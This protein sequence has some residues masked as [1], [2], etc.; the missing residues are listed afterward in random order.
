MGQRNPLQLF[1]D[2]QEE[3]VT[4]EPS[5]EAPQEDSGIMK[6]ESLIKIHESG[7]NNQES[8]IRNQD[9]GTLKQESEDTKTPPLYPLS[10][11]IPEPLNDALDDAV[12][13]TRRSMGRKIRK[14]VLVS[15]AI[16]TML[17]KVEGA[18]GWRA[19]ASEEELRELLGLHNE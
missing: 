5:N 16:E 13:Q 17:K 6:N 9:S 8:G 11:R 3:S 19:I 4:P 7:K 10:V 14:E 2:S 18:G 12:K 15:L 1:N